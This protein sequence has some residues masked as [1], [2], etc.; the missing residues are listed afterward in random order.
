M[1]YY[2]IWAFLLYTIMLIPVF[3]IYE[4]GTAYDNLEATQY[5]PRTIG[6]LGYSTY[7][8]QSIPLD[9]QKIT[10]YCDYGVIGKTSDILYGVNPEDAHGSCMSNTLNENCAPTNP[11]FADQF[12]GSEG[13][14]YLTLDLSEAA[15]WGTDTVDAECTNA[16]AYFYA[17]FTCVQSES[18]L[19]DKYN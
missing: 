3:I 5:E 6:A 10:L 18:E 15:L 7:T 8:C 11:S 19:H 14:D 17:Q 4:N 1:L 12:T 13:Q 16:Y 9:I 2:M